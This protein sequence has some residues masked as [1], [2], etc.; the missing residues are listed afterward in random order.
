MT[1]LPLLLAGINLVVS[2]ANKD[3]ETKQKKNVE[4]NGYHWRACF[5]LVRLSWR[6]FIMLSGMF[7]GCFPTPVSLCVL[8]CTCCNTFRVK[9]KLMALL[10]L[11]GLGQ[12]VGG[13]H[14]S[15]CTSP[16]TTRSA[17]VNGKHTA[18]GQATHLPCTSAAELGSSNGLMIRQTIASPPN[19]MLYFK[20]P[21]H[22]TQCAQALL[23]L[24]INDSYRGSRS[25]H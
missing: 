24:S 21:S 17:H 14:S 18:A 16:S 11:M 5:G 9:W 19:E 25:R 4:C 23:D 1:Q 13:W 3:N 6:A 22:T 8:P 20:K 15:W 10:Q 12:G 2:L 7:L